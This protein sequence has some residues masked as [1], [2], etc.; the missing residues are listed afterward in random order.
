MIFGRNTCHFYS[1]NDSFR[2]IFNIERK[3]FSQYW[4]FCQGKKNVLISKEQN[5]VAENKIPT[6]LYRNKFDSLPANSICFSIIV[7]FVISQ[8]KRISLN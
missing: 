7:S 8:L 3:Y 2:R 6:V 1:P 5:N 4:R